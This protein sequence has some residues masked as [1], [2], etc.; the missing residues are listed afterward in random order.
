MSVL[1]GGRAVKSVFETAESNVQ[2][3]QSVT[4]LVQS[5]RKSHPGG[6][7]TILIGLSKGNKFKIIKK[8]NGIIAILIGLLLP[9]VQ[10]LAVPGGSDLAMLQTALKPGR[11]LGFVMADG[12]VRSTQDAGKRLIDCEGYAM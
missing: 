3:F 10:R 1:I 4:A 8:D 6:V 9:A 5:L 2:A 7:N 11:A 12:S